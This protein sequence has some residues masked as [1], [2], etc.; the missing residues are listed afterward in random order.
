MASFNTVWT[1]NTN[2]ESS[3]KKWS[4]A[5]KVKMSNKTA[6]FK[7]AKDTRNAKKSKGKAGTS[8]KGKTKKGG[9]GSGVRWGRPGDEM[10]YKT[11]S[12]DLMKDSSSNQDV[13]KFHKEPFL[14][15]SPSLPV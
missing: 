9:A 11:N 8:V 2:G 3:Q 10:D 12:H 15:M 5:D 6:G 13:E 1:K 4:T 7:N 14:T